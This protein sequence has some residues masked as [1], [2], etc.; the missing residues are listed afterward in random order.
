MAALAVA[1]ALYFTLAHGFEKP[2]AT[3]GR[4]AGD[5]G[6]CRHRA[7][8]RRP[9]LSARRRDGDRLQHRHRSQPDPGPAH[10]RSPLPKDR[11]SRPAICWR[12]SIR[13]PIRPSSTRLIA[14]RDRDQAQLIN[15]EANLGRYTELAEQGIRHPATGRHA[16]GAS[17][18]AARRVKADE[19]LIE[20]AEVQ[21]SYTRLT[22]PIPGVTGVRQIDVGNIIHPTDPNGLVVVTQIEPISLLFT[23]PQADLPADPGRRWP[24]GR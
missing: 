20:Q 23:L 11:P 1:G 12:R 3:L 9:D 5:A 17:R 7:Q 16:E 2:P 13:V 4:T 24:R 14:N 22:S 8:P 19:A 15:A 10:P 6:R 18:A 21:L